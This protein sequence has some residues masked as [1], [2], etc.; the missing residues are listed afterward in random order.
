MNI[1]NNI[2]I[3]AWMAI[4]GAISALDLFL[5]L[6][7]AQLKYLFVSLVF[8]SIHRKIQWHVRSKICSTPMD[9]RVKMLSV[10]C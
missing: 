3:T 7:C 10:F 4:A 8:V 6:I 1:M 5:W 2:N 9:S